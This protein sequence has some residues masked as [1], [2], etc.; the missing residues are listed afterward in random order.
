MSAA[1][2][3]ST[4]STSLTLPDRRWLAAGVLV[5]AVVGRFVSGWSTPFGFDET[6]SGV[7][8]SQPDV[9]TLVDWCL[10]EIGGPVYYLLLWCW[11]HLFGTNLSALRSFSMAASLAMPFVILR[12]GHP[13]RDTRLYWAV[14]M[15]LWLPALGAA[16]NA[17]CYALL[18]LETTAQAIAFRR[19]VVNTDRQHAVAW[20][21][22][23][24]LAVLTH[25]HAV[26]LAGVQGLIVLAMRP[27][28]AARCWPALLLLVPMAAWM[29]FHLTLLARFATQG[30]WY[31][32][33]KPINLLFVP[34]LILGSVVLGGVAVIAAIVASVHPRWHLRRLD[35]A[36]MAVAVS[37]VVALGVLLA[38]GMVRSSFTPR[39]TTMMGPAILFGMAA[40]VRHVGRDVPR[41]S[42]IILALFAATAL[43]QIGR[44]VIDPVDDVRYNLNLE[45]PSQWLV[46][47]HARRV[48]F[49]WDSP[50]G[51]ISEASRIAEVIGFGP[52][53]AGHPVTV[54]V[55]QDGMRRPSQIIRAAIEA[56]R[57]DS[58]IW[59]SDPTVPG[60]VELPDANVPRQFGWSCRDFGGSHIRML[61]C[62][63][64][65]AV[66]MR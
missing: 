35:R 19:F 36:D 23:S 60:T 3:V 63:R 9:Y 50:T 17:R 61:T 7:I 43:G 11:S 4:Q 1:S 39:Y 59:L 2:L 33:L 21:G 38:I 26:L 16:T 5:L 66:R 64:A 8:A 47:R 54:T 20:V 44:Q 32:L 52:R 40:W 25:Y 28:A 6:F 31:P 24:V 30:A 15:A 14:M 34:E 51:R 22:L 42:A 18:M 45:R 12:W 48:G 29:A 57:I 41:I 46:A 49:L 55:L 65:R 58:L 27:R 62:G 53:Q 37:G 10:N 13:D 56:K